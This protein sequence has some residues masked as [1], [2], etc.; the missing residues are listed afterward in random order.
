MISATLAVS[1]GTVLWFAT[2]SAT[3]YLVTSGDSVDL[4]VKLLSAVLPNTAVNWGFNL[5]VSWE[6]RG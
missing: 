1:V 2:Y 6:A 5:I 4:G 3:A